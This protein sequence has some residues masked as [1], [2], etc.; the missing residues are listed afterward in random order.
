MYDWTI[1]LNRKKSLI[2]F[3]YWSSWEN[4]P[5]ILLSFFLVESLSLPIRDGSRVKSGRFLF[6]FLSFFFFCFGF[7]L[8]SSPDTHVFK[9]PVPLKRVRTFKNPSD[10]AERKRK[11]K[12]GEFLSIK[13]LETIAESMRNIDSRK[14]AKKKTRLPDTGRLDKEITN[15]V[16]SGFPTAVTVVYF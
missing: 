2:D 4:V 10:Q 12:R 13:I 6:F 16:E 5:H 8:V 1:R 7:G 15:D 3:F 11:R 14:A 9:G